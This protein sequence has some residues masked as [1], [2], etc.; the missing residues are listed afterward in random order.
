MWIIAGE[1]GENEVKFPT[2]LWFAKKSCVW[3]FMGFLTL[4]NERFSVFLITL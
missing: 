4:S 1:Q 3:C 2:L